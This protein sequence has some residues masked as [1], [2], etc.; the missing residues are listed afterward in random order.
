MNDFFKLMI[1]DQKAILISAEEQLSIPASIIEKD[2]WVCWL[3]EQVFQLPYQMA[4]K[5][6]TSLSK[7]F[8]LIHRFSEDIDITID[9]TN[10]KSNIDLKTTSRSQLKKISEQLKQQ[11]IELTRNKIMFHIQRVISALQIDNKVDVDLSEN[12]E[13]IKVYYPSILSDKIGYLRNHVL[14]EFGIRNSTEPCESC[15]ISSMLENAFSNAEIQLPKATINVLSPIR[16][17]WEKATLMHL[18][19]HRH[20]LDHLPDR[21]SRHWYDLAMLI[22]SD[23]GKQALNRPDILESVV[24]HKKAFFNASYADYDDC[25]NGK[26][27]L[28][29]DSKGINH[30]KNDYQK[31]HIAGLF[32]GEPVSF[33]SIVERLL[34]TQEK[35]NKNINRA[36]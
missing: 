1:D 22:N 15:N 28:L 27:L 10:F 9:Y 32:I 11:L 33:D 29:P 7:V 8:N 16:T 13:Q 12:G 14:L 3:L 6:G 2:L 20:R 34:E 18:E 30:L 23:I 24:E 21:L 5:G 4:F 19:C 26:F 35:I 31:M 17:F 25:L 36:N